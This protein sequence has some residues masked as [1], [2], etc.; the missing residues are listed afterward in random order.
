MYYFEESNIF[1]EKYLFDNYVVGKSNNYAYSAGI[2][3]IKEVKKTSSFNPLV[4]IGDHGSG[5]THLLCA[6]CNALTKEY[7]NSL[8]ISY[9]RMDS[10]INDV[11]NCIKNNEIEKLYDHYKNLDV[12]VID[13]FHK[14]I[15]KKSCQ[16][17]FFTIFNTLHSQNKKIIISS[18]YSIENLDKFNSTE[19]TGVSKMNSRLISRLMW[20]LTVNIESFDYETLMAILRKKTEKYDFNDEIL[21]YIASN[22]YSSSIREIE[23]IILKISAYSI[24]CKKDLSVEEVKDI[25]KNDSAVKRISRNIR[26][27]NIIEVV[28]KYFNL[29]KRKIIEKNRRKELILP[30]Q[31]CMYLATELTTLGLESI[32]EYFSGRDHSTIIYARDSIK[33]LV[34]S[35]DSYKKILNNI[36]KMLITS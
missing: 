17:F 16:D 8:V 3:M 4:I 5:K 19:N 30:R 32:G 14:I 25:I 2:N 22:F 21:E 1:F 11:I 18:L 26:I 36:K 9:T 20:G 24:L 6:I 29:E 27:D 7:D 35:D 15:G 34:K 33:K 23:G 10:F 13:D 28:S 12:L 31:I